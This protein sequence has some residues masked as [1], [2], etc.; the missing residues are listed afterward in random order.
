MNSKDIV[1]LEPLD[2]ENYIFVKLFLSQYLQL[3]ILDAKRT[4]HG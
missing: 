3:W 2:K 4:M 1:F